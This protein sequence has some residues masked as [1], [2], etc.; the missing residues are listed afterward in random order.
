MFYPSGGP[1]LCIGQHFPSHMIF[2]NR[3]LDLKCVGGVVFDLQI[4]PPSATAAS[5][6]LGMPGVLR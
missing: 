5:I 1:Q 3:T 2:V 4:Q 6:P